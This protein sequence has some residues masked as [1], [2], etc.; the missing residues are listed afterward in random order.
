MESTDAEL[1]LF[2]KRSRLVL[3]LSLSG[4]FVAAGLWLGIWHGELGVR[5][6]GWLSVAFFGGCGGYLARR[7]AR[8]TPVLVIDRQGIIDNASGVAVGRIAWHEIAD[9]TIGSI[10]RQRFL[11]IEVH[12]VPA[13]RARVSRVR[14]W[15]MRA[16]MAMG[17][18]PVNI[19]QGVVPM[20]IA[21]LDGT[22]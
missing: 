15:V 5:V 17:F 20:P 6:A 11:G 3:L 7:L 19:P 4:M 22:D 1:R 16:N 12:D 2:A 14:G 21:E 8:R 13:L 10:G 18:S 9:V